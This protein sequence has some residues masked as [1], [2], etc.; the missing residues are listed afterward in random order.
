MLSKIS[1]TRL[2]D[3]RLENIENIEEDD[4][5]TIDEKK[6]LYTIDIE[7]KSFDE[8]Q[9]ETNL[10]VD[11][12]LMNLTTLELKGKLEQTLGDRYKKK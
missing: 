7:P 2:G 12:L 4:N 9:K 6:I 10:S 3:S 1:P 5:L 8:I 11:E